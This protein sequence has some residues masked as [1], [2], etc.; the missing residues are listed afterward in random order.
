[1]Q[2]GPLERVSIPKE[3]DG[4]NRSYGF[5]TY[6]H[7]VSVPYALS[8][9]YGTKLHNRE[10]RLNNRNSGNRTNNQNNGMG[11]IVNQN[12]NNGM[13]SVA[14]QIHNQSQ[15]MEPRPLLP[16][17]PLMHQFQ[18]QNPYGNSMLRGNNA[19]SN[20]LNMT[21][22][23]NS[24]MLPRP[25]AQFTL[26][27]SNPQ[28]DLNM[29]MALSSQMLSSGNGSDSNSKV[30]NETHQHQSKMLHRHD[31]RSHRNTNYSNDRERRREDRKRDQSREREDWVRNRSRDY[32]NDR[33]G[34]SN[35]NNDNNRR[36]ND[37]QF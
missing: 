14:N 24:H 11:N 7:S 27:P 18:I 23:N 20:P 12:Q 9:F 35:R 36:R 2:G 28:I 3:K 34:K 8:V 19:L 30:N 10:I 37:R 32:K 31:N 22:Y 15:S 1:M 6:K 26:P 21:P 25:T 16:N 33:N 13:G 17:I 29:L 5:I 4:T